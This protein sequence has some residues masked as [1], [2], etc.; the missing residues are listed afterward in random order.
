MLFFK[1]VS[2][3]AGEISMHGFALG[4]YTFQ[5]AKEDKNIVSS[6]KILRLDIS[7]MSDS[8]QAGFK[9]KTDFIHDGLKRES[10][11]DLREAYIDIFGKSFDLRA[12]KQVITWGAGDLVFINDIFPKSWD[13]FYS[14]K[15]MEYLKLGTESLK[16]GLYP[17][18]FSL[19][20]ILMP[21][22]QP[23]EMPSREKFIFADPF[24]G[25]TE[26]RVNMPDK[27]LDDMETALRIYRRAGNGDISLYAYS[28]YYHS[29]SAIADTSSVTYFHPP[30]KVYGASYQI[31]SMGGVI[32]LEAG[33]YD[34]R[35]DEKGS[36]PIVENS[37]YKYLLGYGRQITENL[38]LGA[39]Y[40]SEIMRN[41]QKYK[42]NLPSGFS[43]EHKIK[44]T[45]TLRL[46]QFL[47]YETW[48]LSLFGFYGIDEKDYMLIPEASYKMTD[49]LSLVLGGNVIEG[50]KD[51][52]SFG[53]FKENDN[54]YMRIKYDF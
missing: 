14:G 32:S 25:I 30:L 10:M 47:K 16:L 48:K 45:V 1:S 33:Y 50:D 12:G 36:D 42:D 22:F 40:Y 18:F 46:T 24:S 6:E 15:D 53:R 41:Y 31:N 5:T 37:K 39:Q 23:D 27:K 54:V 26:R 11:M 44:Q 8:G 28:G 17:E 19:E 13:A 3:S 34:S 35:D 51:Y 4:T 2:S 52:T 43:L 29:P 38:H 49:E 21:A 20:V 9:A 7:S